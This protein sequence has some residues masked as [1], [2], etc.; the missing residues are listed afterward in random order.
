MSSTR[1]P[2]RAQGS[3][4]GWIVSYRLPRMISGAPVRNQPW[5]ANWAADHFAA[6]VKGISPVFFQGASRA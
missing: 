5:S 1:L 6:E 4:M 3:A 2:S